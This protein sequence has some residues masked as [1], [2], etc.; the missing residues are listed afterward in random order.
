MAHLGFT[1][2]QATHSYCRQRLQRFH[3]TND[4]KV[5]FDT[6]DNIVTIEAQVANRTTSANAD[7][8]K[9]IRLEH[10]PSPRRAGA[11]RSTIQTRTRAIRFPLVRVFPLRNCL[12]T[13][14]GQGHAASRQ[15]AS[16]QT[17]PRFLR[18][19]IH[20]LENSPWECTQ[21]PFGRFSEFKSCSQ[22]GFLCG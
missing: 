4:T 16:A 14:R 15:S 1:M 20:A 5:T 6:V 10:G 13:Q 19:G 9:V 18:V 7:A 2:R 8:R 3:V 12:G 22:L 17:K 21:N 11:A